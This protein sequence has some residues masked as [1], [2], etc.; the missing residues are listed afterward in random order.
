[1]PVVFADGPGSV[2]KFATKAEAAVFR[3]FTRNAVSKTERILLLLDLVI[4]GTERPACL[5]R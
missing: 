1:M 4:A 3:N 5:E 2:P